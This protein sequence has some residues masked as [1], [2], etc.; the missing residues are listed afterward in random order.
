MSALSLLILFLA[1]CLSGWAS[2][3][4]GIGGGVVITPLLYTLFPQLPPAGIISCSLG[5]ILM[6]SSLN[7]W[8]FWRQ[9]AYQSRLYLFMGPPLAMGIL[10]SSL[11]VS[12]L[13]PTATKTLLG[14]LILGA[15]GHLILRPPPS[16]S[17]SLPHL[18]KGQKILVAGAS[19]FSGILSGVSGV[20]GGLLLIPVMTTIVK[21]PLSQIPP[22]LNVAMAMGALTGVTSYALQSP[23][24]SLLGGHPFESWRVGYFNPVL[25]LLVFSGALLTA[26]WG[27]RLSKQI[28]PNRARW[29]FVALLGFFALR[30]LL[31]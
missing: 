6:N 3:F 31:T 23:P 16:S 27:V 13:S 2:A 19:L 12:H 20:G 21:A 24:E 9:K 8:H 11:L 14:L 26:R 30:M 18:T 28:E 17:S 29:F 15:M 25:S 4:F 22:Y 10:G 7:S 1:G 5:V